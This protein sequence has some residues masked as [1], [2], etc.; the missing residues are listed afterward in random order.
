MLEFTQALLE[1][2]GTRRLVSVQHCPAGQ[3]Q[4]SSLKLGALPGTLFIV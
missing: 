2:A 3:S 1:L 4:L